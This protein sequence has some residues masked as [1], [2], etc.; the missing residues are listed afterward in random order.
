MLSAYKYFIRKISRDPSQF[1]MLIQPKNR[2]QA[3]AIERLRRF[4]EERLQIFNARLR[5]I[6]VSNVEVI[7]APLFYDKVYTKYR[8]KSELLISPT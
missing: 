2:K 8:R 1:K 6:C 4:Q 3:A 5:L 7:V